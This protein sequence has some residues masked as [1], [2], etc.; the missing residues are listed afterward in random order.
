LNFILDR[1]TGPGRNQ[2]KDEDWFNF[3]TTLKTAQATWKAIAAKADH[4]RT[5]AIP[6][7]AKDAD[8]IMAKL[9]LAA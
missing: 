4:L 8:N 1:L 3:V 9:K 7:A 2:I 5:V 6:V